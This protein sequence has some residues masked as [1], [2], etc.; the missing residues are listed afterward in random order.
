MSVDNTEIKI[1]SKMSKKRLQKDIVDI[2]KNPLSD[3]GI[4]YAHD[5]ENMLK[6]YAI[7]FGP[8]DTIYRYGGYCFEFNFPSNYPFSPPKL[9]YLTNDNQTRFHPNLY[10]NGKVC[11]SILNTWKGEQWTSCQTIKSILLMLV[12]LL[13]NKSLLNEPGIKETHSS[14]KSYHEII[15]YKNLEIAILRNLKKKMLHLGKCSCFFSIYKKYIC[16]NKDKI[17]EYITNLKNKNNKK[18]KVT[19]RIYGMD[20]IINYDY[21]HTEFIKVINEN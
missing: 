7:I 15:T 18:S 9:K 3:N 6:G 8:D 1:M 10:R 16:E 2:I 13:H 11:I 17:I 20:C 12:T 19:A 21:L 5:E 4:Y 14:F